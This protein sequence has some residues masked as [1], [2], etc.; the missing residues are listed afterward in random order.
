MSLHARPKHRRLSTF[1]ETTMRPYSSHIKIIHLRRMAAKRQKRH[2]YYCK[3]L[4]T[5]QPQLRRTAE[6]L[7]ARS[8]CGKDSKSNIVAACHFCNAMRHRL[9]PRL[10]APE[11]AATVKA[12]V[13]HDK[14]HER[15]P[16]WKGFS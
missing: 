14:W 11:Y 6:H 1:K 5:S 12:L 15:H 16:A 3:R 2:C 10:R 9:F 7:I 13:S 4:M 8:D